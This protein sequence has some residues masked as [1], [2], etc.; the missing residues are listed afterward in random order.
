MHFD[1]LSH[2]NAL[3]WRKWPHHIVDRRPS[4]TMRLTA[5]SNIDARVPETNWLL[6]LYS[7]QECNP[8]LPVCMYD[9]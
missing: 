9:M 7:T 4:Q 3:Q 2:S 5:V 6:L 1:L 8:Q